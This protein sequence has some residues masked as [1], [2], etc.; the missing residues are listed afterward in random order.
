MNFLSSIIL[1][2]TALFSVL[3]GWLVMS[4]VSILLFSFFYSPAWLVPLAILIDGYIG[5]FATFPTLS[6]ASLA[7][8]VLVE[9]LRPK[10]VDFNNR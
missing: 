1:Y 8:F 6:F 4:L 3:Q 2:T 5:S 10:I 9:F 7:W